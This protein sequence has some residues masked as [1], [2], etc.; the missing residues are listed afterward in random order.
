MGADIHLYAEMRLP[1]GSWVC[2]RDLNSAIRNQGL[3]SYEEGKSVPSHSYWRLCDRNYALF[4]ALAGVR[5]EGPKPKDL[6]EDVSEYVQYW[7]DRWDGDAHSHSWCTAQEFMTAWIRVGRDINNPSVS[8]YHKIALESGMNH[9]V[10]AFM[11]EMCS[12]DSEISS[13]ANDY[14]FV[15]WFDN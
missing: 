5:G 9:A 4:A 8:E 15:F 1:S 12:V 2:V 3:R 10:L 7:A 14:R 6:P 13:D 11:W